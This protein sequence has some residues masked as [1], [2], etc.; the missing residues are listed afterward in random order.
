M[1]SVRRFRLRRSRTAELA[2]L[3][4]ALDAIAAENRPARRTPA[5]RAA[6]GRPV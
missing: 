6:F 5:V 1:S 2:R 3:L 4:A